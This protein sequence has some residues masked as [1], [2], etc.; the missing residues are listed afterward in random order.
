MQKSQMNVVVIGGAAIVYGGLL[1]LLG[2]IDVRQMA[3]TGFAVVILALIPVLLI[4]L[5]TKKFAAEVS[6]VNSQLKASNDALA[7]VK[8]RL[9]Q[10]TTLDELT[11]CSNK[12][13]FED[14]LMQH[15][16]MSERGAYS[17]TV[18]VTQLDQFSEIV[19]RQGLARGNEV[20]QLFSRIVKAAL[21]EVDVVARLDTD[22]F[23]LVLSGCS[24]ED[25]LVIISRVSQLISQ[26]QVNDK[27]DL[28]ITASG[29]ITSYHGTEQ[30]GDLIGHAEQALLSAIELG[31]DRVAGYNYVEPVV[32]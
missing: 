24:E 3:F 27:D 25:A 1:A 31:G 19:D 4:N 9:A 6:E 7:E 16:A 26:I 14:L 32:A 15:V 13:H 8:T 12:R 5:S 30:P 20:L 28:K 11:G 29:G 2:D 18:A 17:F 22:K 21:R 10:I 23:G